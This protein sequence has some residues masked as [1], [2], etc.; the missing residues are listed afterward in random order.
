MTPSGWLTRAAAAE[1]LG[2]SLDAFDGWVRRRGV[3]PSGRM[4]RV[5]LW[6][7]EDLDRVLRSD[8]TQVSRRLR[9]VPSVGARARAT[10]GGGG[11]SVG[12]EDGGPRLKKA[13]G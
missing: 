3:R 6:K 2:R 5:P 12:S 8:A 11:A 1:Y 13:V 4:G 9:A 7:R 10:V